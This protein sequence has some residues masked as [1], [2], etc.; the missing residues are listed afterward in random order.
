MASDGDR[1]EL[2]IKTLLNTDDTWYNLFSFTYTHFWEEPFKGVIPCFHK[3]G[4]VEK[5]SIPFLLCLLDGANADIIGITTMLGIQQVVM[6]L[7][8]LSLR[9]KNWKSI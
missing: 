6:S 4:Q 2:L 9:R 8:Q 7:L 1:T 3:L 5:R